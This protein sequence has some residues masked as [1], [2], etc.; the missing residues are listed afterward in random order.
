M[1]SL[2]RDCGRECYIKQQPTNTPPRTKSTDLNRIARGSGSPATLNRNPPLSAA[3]C[4]SMTP[5]QTPPEP[6]ANRQAC[7][8]LGAFADSC[9]RVSMWLFSS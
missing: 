2:D 8:A 3:A 7:R 6:L 4:A 5:S 9:G 1:F